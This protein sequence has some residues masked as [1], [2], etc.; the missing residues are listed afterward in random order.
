MLS[1]YVFRRNGTRNLSNAKQDAI[2]ILIYFRLAEP[3]APES[4]EFHSLSASNG[5]I[6]SPRW[7]EGGRRPDE[8]RAL[9]STDSAEGEASN[10]NHE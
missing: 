5:K 3:D 7:G 2:I 1:N 8:V 9:I 10:S 4:C 6:P